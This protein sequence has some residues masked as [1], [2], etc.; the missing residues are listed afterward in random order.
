MIKELVDNFMADLVLSGYSKS[1]LQYYQDMLY[2][3]VKYCKDNNIATIEDFNDDHYTRFLRLVKVQKS[4]LSTYQNGVKSF[5]RWMIN[6]GKVSH[7]LV[8]KRIIY[9]KKQPQFYSLTKIMHIRE[10]LTDMVIRTAFDVLFET[11]IR[12]TE[13]C[14][15][16]KP[17]VNWNSGSIV[18][19]NTKGNADR[20]V[21]VNQKTLNNMFIV[22]AENSEYV[23]MFAKEKLTRQVLYYRIWLAGRAIGM[24]VSP[25]VLRHSFASVFTREVRDI[26]TLQVI[27]GHKSVAT[28]E[29]YANVFS[30]TV[31]DRLKEFNSIIEKGKKYVSTEDI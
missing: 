9:D 6:H 2:R 11:G 28:T 17:D 18:L 21:F 4:T 12:S 29:R 19:H 13:L 26:R 31:E 20:T 30:T 8:W 15:I 1:T 24:K 10:K 23:F 3:M 16:K 5:Y 25:R 7:P 22:A 14:N 27:L